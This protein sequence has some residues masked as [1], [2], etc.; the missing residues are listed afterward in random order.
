MYC[1]LILSLFVIEFYV[2]LG[3]S[4]RNYSFKESSGS[5]NIILVLSKPLSSGFNLTIVSAP[6]TSDK[7]EYAHE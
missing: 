3:F 5:A 2:K 7:G 4:E 6:L 1:M